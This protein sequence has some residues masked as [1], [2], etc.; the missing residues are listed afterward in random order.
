MLPDMKYKKKG[1]VAVVVRDTVIVMGGQD[2]TGNYLKSVECFRFDRNSWQELPEMHEV[3]CN[4]TAVN[5]RHY[6]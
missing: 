6:E 2:E 4:A 3:R 5:C 1:F